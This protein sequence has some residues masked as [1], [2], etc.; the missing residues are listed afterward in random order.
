MIIKTTK[1]GRRRFLS[2]AVAAST[3]AGAAMAIPQR[4]LRAAEPPLPPPVIDTHT[5][6]FDPTRPEGV[7]WPGK[8]GELDRPV[9]PA[10]WQTLVKPLGVTGT[11]VVEASS[12]VEDN[13][14]LLDLAARHDRE[15]LP[16]MLGIVGVVGSLPLGDPT[17][18]EFI[19]RFAKQR[20]YRG[21][22][23]NGD[24]LL[25]ALADKASTGDIARL[26]DNDLS[27][28]INGGKVFDA[29]TAAAARFPSLR[30]IVNHMGNTPVSDKG[31]LPE[32]LQSIKLAAQ[33]PNVF[34]KVS[35]MAENAAHTMKLQK[36]PLDPAFYV[37]WLDAA[38]AAFGEK[39]LMFGSNWPV[40][41][42]AS[43]YAE[44]LDIVKPYVARKGPE[45]ERWFYAEAS[46]AAYRWVE[47]KT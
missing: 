42:K 5:H 35:A 34:M 10:E 23:V 14:W 24:K 32:W 21:I 9:L 37:P 29:A 20:L 19:D 8:G 43:S 2:Q 3:A 28:D 4:Q 33:H 18:A 45:A 13:Q 16:G 7:P 46:R 6:F 44:V 41:N 38:W 12:W 27:I 11:V 17:C 1:I 15:R 36:P 22:R 31:P 30:I 25:A 40:S 39:R 47:T 26:A